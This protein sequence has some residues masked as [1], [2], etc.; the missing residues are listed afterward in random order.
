MEDGGERNLL[1]PNAGPP[2]AESITDLQMLSQKL[3][4][5]L[6]GRHSLI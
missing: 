5:L 2:I 4:K 3:D 1:K 6:S